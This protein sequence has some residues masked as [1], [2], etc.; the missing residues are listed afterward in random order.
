MMTKEEIIRRK[1]QGA[2]L[3][4]VREAAGYRSARSAAL[5]N[6]WAEST[7]R[8]HEGGTRTIGQ[9]DAE[10]YAKRFRYKGANITAALILFGDERRSSPS[11]APDS[12]AEPATPSLASRASKTTGIPL[13]DIPGIREQL[14]IFESRIVREAVEVT[15]RKVYSTLVHT[16][17]TVDV[18]RVL[19]AN[20]LKEYEDLK[21]QRIELAKLE[22]QTQIEAG[23]R[24]DDIPIGHGPKAR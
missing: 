17:P 1:E 6:K 22:S 24:R 15:A 4:K 12:T 7:Y 8:A 9:D 13:T 16:L 14:E 11:A 2:R 23:D 18:F 10:A 3:R 20:A 19:V 5:D 21:V